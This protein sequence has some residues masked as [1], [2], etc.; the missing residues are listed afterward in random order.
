MANTRTIKKTV[1][2][3]NTESKVVETAPVVKPK[4]AIQLTDR[5]F[6]ENT[7]SWN[8]GFRAIESQRDI[9]IPANA[10]K[11]AQLNVAEIMAQIQEGNVMFC[12]TYG[13][14][15]NAYLKIL[16]D[17]IRKYVFSLDET[18]DSEP[19]ILD[20]KS[21]KELLEI[22][23]KNEFKKRLSE[24]VVTEGDKKM[25][26]PLAKKVGIEEVAGYKRT[27]IENISGYTF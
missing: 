20:E 1:T 5:V 2:E 23:N 10:K 8:L 24:L 12:G 17:D 13:M 22:N 27:E 16:D 15:N 14:C 7:R 25:I 3:T 18:D 6:I 11:Y 21:V 19:I 4:K 9:T 26:V